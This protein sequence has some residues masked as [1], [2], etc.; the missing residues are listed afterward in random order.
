MEQFIFH[1][2]FPVVNNSKAAPFLVK[3]F[4]NRI[5]FICDRTHLRRQRNYGWCSYSNCSLLSF[6]HS[7][8]PRRGTTSRKRIKIRYRFASITI[9]TL[10]SH[11]LPWTV[12]IFCIERTQDQDSSVRSRSRLTFFAE[13]QSDAALDR[14][15]PPAA[16]TYQ[17]HLVQVHAWEWCHGRGVD[18]H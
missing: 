14:A 6:N 3:R 13:S 10:H 17:E 12:L 18:V 8:S 9:I 15:L 4:C 1:L 5:F 7:T 11:R 2:E 16:A